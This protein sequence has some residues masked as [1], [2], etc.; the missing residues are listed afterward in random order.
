MPGNEEFK[1]LVRRLS[2]PCGF[3]SEALAGPAV[4]CGSLWCRGR[5]WGAGQD[6][7]RSRTVN[8]TF[9]SS[10]GLNAVNFKLVMLRSSEG[11]LPDAAGVVPLFYRSGSGL[12]SERKE[13]GEHLVA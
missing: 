9:V 3:P 13:K 8:G 2:A 10:L 4:R 7:S 5:C 1:P 6:W 11:P 12:G